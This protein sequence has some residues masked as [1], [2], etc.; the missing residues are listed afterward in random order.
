[1]VAATMRLER[2]DFEAIL[3]FLARVDSIDT[4]EPYAREVLDSLKDLIPCDRVGYDEAD[5][6]ARRFLDTTPETADDDALYWATG[7]CPITDYRI[8]TGDST[9]ARVSDV[10][11]R[12]RWRELP[13]YREYYQPVG[14]DHILDLNMSP[15][16]H[17]FRTLT[18]FRGG[19]RPDFSERDRLVLEMLRPHLR[20]REARA[21]LV[22]RAADKDPVDLGNRA[23]D[24]HVTVREREILAMVAAGKTNAQ[25]AAELWVTPGTVKKHLENVYVKLGV[26]SRAAAASRVQSAVDGTLQ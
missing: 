6:D 21:A 15:V 14:L 10:I 26:G 13:L 23:R 22:V 3:D 1:M 8:R 16:R 25:I 2:A 7:P 5:V 11:G 19:D 20:A 24:P 12:S 4:D 18:L 17:A 9:A